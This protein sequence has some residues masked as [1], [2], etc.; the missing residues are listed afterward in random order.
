M[1][2]NIT[3]IISKLSFFMNIPNKDLIIEIITKL[4]DFILFQNG[5]TT[6]TNYEKFKKKNNIN[7]NLKVLTDKLDYHKFSFNDFLNPDKNTSFI[8]P[9]SVLVFLS[10]NLNFLKVINFFMKNE[11]ITETILPTEFTELSS[12]F[13][14]LKSAFMNQIPSLVQSVIPPLLQSGMELIPILKSSMKQSGVNIE[15]LPQ[16]L[17]N[18]MVQYSKD[19]S[20]MNLQ[21][22]VQNAIMQSG[23]DLSKMNL[24][25]LVQNAIKQSGINI[26]KI[27]QPVNKKLLLQERINELKGHYV[28]SSNTDT[29]IESDTK[30]RKQLKKELKK[31]IKQESLPTI[32]PNITDKKQ[33]PLHNQS[34][35]PLYIPNSPQQHPKP[36]LQRRQS[37]PSPQPQSHP[38]QQS[39]STPSPPLQRRQSLPS[40]QSHPPQQSQ[41]SPS[42]PLQRRQ[43]SSQPQPQRRQSSPSQQSQ[44]S[45]THR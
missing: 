31:L 8:L 18:A 23:V 27:D 28:T 13:N 37:L 39:Q 3:D 11:S 9:P 2:N 42:P 20:K 34:L 44:S 36:P 45:H 40:P 26:D 14:Y 1:S 21:T 4:K 17:Q 19:D 15:N 6:I 12:S 30:S 24:Q 10:L 22:L 29:S 5:E 25:T 35:T 38:P 43:S 7:T 16:L 41:S 33:K 32:A